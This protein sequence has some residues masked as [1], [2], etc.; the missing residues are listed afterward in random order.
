MPP[1]THRLTIDAAARSP[2]AA[3]DPEALLMPALYGG[4]D[5]GELTRRLLSLGFPRAMLMISGARLAAGAPLVRS[6]VCCI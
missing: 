4:A 1:A 2:P 5:G 6:E 3:A